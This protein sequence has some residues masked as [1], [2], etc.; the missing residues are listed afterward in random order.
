MRLGETRK[1]SPAST[2]P[3]TRVPKGGRQ[4]HVGLTLRLAAAFTCHRHRGSFVLC[5]DD[6][7]A[8]TQ[9]LVQGLVLRAARSA[10]LSNVG[11]HVLRHT[12]CSHLAMRGG[13]G[14]AIQKL[15]GHSNLATT[16]RYMHMSPTAI[17]N[18]IR[19]LDPPPQFPVS[20]EIMEKEN[21]NVGIVNR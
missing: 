4:R 3:R 7:A 14:G 19:L 20:G 21:A 11:V 15:A 16:E 5:S 9:R 1:P 8:L 13:T 10:N 17:D 6:G 12:F 2:T 18:T